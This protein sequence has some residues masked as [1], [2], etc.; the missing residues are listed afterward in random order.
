LV[1][2]FVCLRFLWALRN[3]LIPIAYLGQFL[4]PTQHCYG[5]LFTFRPWGHLHLFVNSIESN[6]CRT[7]FQRHAIYGWWP[8]IL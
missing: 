7:N 1:F 2:L 5:S 3:T 6:K 8:K 4:I